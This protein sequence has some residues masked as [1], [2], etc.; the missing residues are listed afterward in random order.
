MGMHRD[1]LHECR[2]PRRGFTGY[3]VN[4]CSLTKPFRNALPLAGRFKCLL[5]LQYL[6]VDCGIDAA[7]V[8][9]RQRTALMA[10][11]EL[12]HTNI[13]KLLVD[14]GHC[15]ISFKNSRIKTSWSKVAANGHDHAIRILFPKHRQEE[16]E[17]R[18]SL[19]KPEF[20]AIIVMTTTPTT[21]STFSTAPSIRNKTPL[22]TYHPL[23]FKTGLPP[24]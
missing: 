1:I 19:M 17:N 9:G 24:M 12:G 7:A 22:P 5:S 10:V 2:L 8:D 15:N 13:I 4:P 20:A 18:R 21:L 11:A 16:V 23:R 6:I 14:G 3:P